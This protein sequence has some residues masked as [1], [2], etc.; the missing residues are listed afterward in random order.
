MSSVFATLRA[1]VGVNAVTPI[2]SDEARQIWQHATLL[3]ESN[4]QDKFV[5]N[6]SVEDCIAGGLEAILAE[7]CVDLDAVVLAV[8]NG[9]D[10]VK[11]TWSVVLAHCD[12][13][14][15]PSRDDLLVTTEDYQLIMQLTH[16]EWLRV[17]S[18]SALQ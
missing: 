18:L 1:I 10:G 9:H 12:D 13:F 3:L 11:V 16:E 15:A 5:V 6:R 4:T 8:L 7:V 17:L 2:P 14:W